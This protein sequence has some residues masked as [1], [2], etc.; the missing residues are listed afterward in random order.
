MMRRFWIVCGLFAT[1]VTLAAPVPKDKDQEPP[2][3]TDKQ[4][5]LAQNNLKQIV[6]TMHNYES[7]YGNFPAD[8][9]D[10]NGKSLLSWRVAML[11]YSGKDEDAEL[12]KLF[13]IDEPWD[14]KTNKPLSEKLPKIYAP[15]R[16]KAE[17]GQ[18]F[19]R[20]FTG[21]G[22]FFDSKKGQRITNITDGTS[23]SIAVIEAGESVVWSK[24]GTD[25]P[26]V[27]KKP[28]PALGK[29]IDGNFHAALLD[30]SVIVVKRSFKEESMKAMITIAGGE[31]IET[32]DVIVV[33]E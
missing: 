22:A 20:G 15:V 10:K 25:I 2:P 17:K 29:D 31:V 6:L 4:R 8:I 11:A 5:E 23:N 26:F 7:A 1:A 16:V 21:N 30:G 3:A 9:V 27:P 14:S 12:F 28:L 24:P 18:T 13:K 19:Y 33:K 32:S